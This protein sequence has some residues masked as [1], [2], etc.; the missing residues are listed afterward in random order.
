MASMA[1]NDEALDDNFFAGHLDTIERDI[2]AAKNRTRYAMNLALIEIGARNSKL[3]KKAI[4]VAKRIGPIE[5]D[6]GETG[7]QTPEAVSYIKKVV[8]HR[9]KAHSRG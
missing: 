9:K 5:V 6:H 4:A 1:N 7:C 2:H 8:A 3:E